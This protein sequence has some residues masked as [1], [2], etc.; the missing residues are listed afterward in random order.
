M[1]CS[2]LKSC[3]L[4]SGATHHPTLVVQGLKSAPLSH[5]GSS[6][7]SST[8]ELPKDSWSDPNPAVNPVLH[9]LDVVLY[10]FCSSYCLYC[11]GCHPDPRYYLQQGP[12][13]WGSIIVTDTFL[14]FQLFPL[15]GQGGLSEFLFLQ[16][17]TS[18]R[19]WLSYVHA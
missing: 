9:H 2:G 4:F 11:Q 10:G 1:R 15:S 14:F 5:E 19:R 7:V 17:N 18:G 13:T 16:T 12:L 8:S 6:P 3:H